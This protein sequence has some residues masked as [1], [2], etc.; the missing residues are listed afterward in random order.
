MNNINEKAVNINNLKDK[1]NSGASFST[2]KLGAN[3][4]NQK[5]NNLKLISVLV[6]ILVVYYFF[7]LS[8]NSNA[9]E[10]PALNDEIIETK[11]SANVALIDDLQYGEDCDSFEKRICNKTQNLECSINSICDCKK[12]WYFIENT[13][14]N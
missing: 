9:N 7:V 8:L 2:F 12:D 3:A 11:A 5:I 1:K 6:L 14:G 4:K 13:C 10:K